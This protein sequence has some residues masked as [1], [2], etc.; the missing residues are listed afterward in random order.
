MI[1]QLVFKG[2]RS[3]ESAPEKAHDKHPIH[4]CDDF[5]GLSEKDI[6]TRAGLGYVKESPISEM[7]CNNCN[8]WL[9]PTKDERCGGC[10]LFKG[11]VYPSGYCTNWA[12]ATVRVILPG[13]LMCSQFG[14]P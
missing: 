13:F 7:R 9:P 2:C 1:A 11:P 6:K 12:L 5:A 10:L 4:P 8:L 3:K 14:Q